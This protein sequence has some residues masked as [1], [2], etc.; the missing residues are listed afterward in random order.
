MAELS[1]C[2]AQFQNIVVAWNEAATN[3]LILR[4]ISFGMVYEMNHQEKFIVR[5]KFR[6]RSELK[7]V[8]RTIPQSGGYD[9]PQRAR[10]FVSKAC[11]G[12]H[13]RDFY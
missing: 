6:K 11:F 10:E 2:K 8:S 13:D 1:I 12:F 9:T 5:L 3:I 7:F 4:N